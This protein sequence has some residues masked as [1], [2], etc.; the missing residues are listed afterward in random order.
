[1][2]KRNEST[3]NRKIQKEEEA[4]A[5]GGKRSYVSH[6]L[7]CGKNFAYGPSN[8]RWNVKKC[9]REEKRRENYAMV[10]SKFEYNNQSRCCWIE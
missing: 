1:M 5:Y 4:E 6:L 8:I 3:Q 9:V 2:K 10:W 7:P